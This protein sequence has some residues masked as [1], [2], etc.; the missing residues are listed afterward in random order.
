MLDAAVDL[1]GKSGHLGSVAVSGF[2]MLPT[3]ARVERLAVEFSPAGLVFGDVLVFR[4]RGMLVVHRLVQRRQ[5]EGSLRLRTRGDGTIGFDPWV[6]PGSVIGR[7]VAV[8][9]NDRTWRNLRNPGARFYGRALAAHD[10]G[11]GCLGAVV[12]KFGGRSGADWRWRL[13]R[14]DHFGLRFTHRLFFRALHPV[15]P[16]P[17]FNGSCTSAESVEAR[18]YTSRFVRA[19]KKPKKQ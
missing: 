18:C 4:Q 10:L 1:I 17:D 13:G 19:R 15:V 11:W 16:A 8:G 6:D 7:V 14:L 5:H 2:S 12:M 9:Y 3:F